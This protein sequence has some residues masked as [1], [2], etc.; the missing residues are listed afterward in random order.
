L[1]AGCAS[2]LR[3][4]ALNLLHP[5]D[6]AILSEALESVGKLLRTELIREL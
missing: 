1:E 4:E 2:V 6:H 5:L 3:Y